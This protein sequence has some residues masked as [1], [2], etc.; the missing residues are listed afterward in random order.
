ML[1]GGLYSLVVQS[2][3]TADQVVFDLIDGSVALFLRGCGGG[4]RF[5]MP[6]IPMLPPP[7]HA[8]I[9]RA[10]GPLSLPPSAG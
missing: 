5:F 4:V 10:P 6:K 3:D 8:L 2:R 1:K 7:C 9:G